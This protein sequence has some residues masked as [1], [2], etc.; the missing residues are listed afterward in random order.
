MSGGPPLAPRAPS[1]RG[2]QSRHGYNDQ[3]APQ[4]ALTE[5]ELRGCS[6]A[7]PLPSPGVLRTANKSRRESAAPIAITKY[8]GKLVLVRDPNARAS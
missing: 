8:W 6:P 2:L 3:H 5:L 1:C 7:L 4:L